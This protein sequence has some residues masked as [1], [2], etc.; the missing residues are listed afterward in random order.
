MQID[1]KALRRIMAAKGFNEASLSREA[2]ISQIVLNNWLTKG[3]RPRTDTLGK[4]A[5]A[6][7]VDIYDIA[8][9]D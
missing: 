5:K 4:V 8:R 1:T 6:L 3:S 2:G 7:D 9:E